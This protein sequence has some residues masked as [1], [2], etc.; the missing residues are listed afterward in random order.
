[1]EQT[2]SNR[3]LRGNWYEE[4]FFDADT[5]NQIGEPRIRP[6]NDEV[7]NIPRIKRQNRPVADVFF[8]DKD[9]PE[10]FVSDYQRTYVRHRNCEETV[11]QRRMNATP[12]HLAEI[13][14]AEPGRYIP[15]YSL[16]PITP[17]EQFQT[18]YNTTYKRFN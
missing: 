1:M 16:K 15:N 5:R 9:D 3:T 17:E 13:L 12:Q 18:T 7:E 6:K 8:P 14:D 10:R 2:F 11:T 4:R